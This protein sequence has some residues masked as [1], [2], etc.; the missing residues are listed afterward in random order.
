MASPNLAEV[1][2]E[3]IKAKLSKLVEK[4]PPEEIADD[5]FSANV[6]T[7]EVYEQ[8]FD[9]RRPRKDK[10]RKLI[11]CLMNAVK[12]DYSVFDR[13]CSTLEKSDKKGV[14]EWAKI[15]RGDSQ[16]FKI[17]NYMYNFYYS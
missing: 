7:E 13:F 16:I 6:I 17:S 5:L 9:A 3:A 11:L 4:L 15:L 1:A 8:A 2:Y 12:L 10:A 14:H